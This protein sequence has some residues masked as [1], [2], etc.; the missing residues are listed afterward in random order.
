[1][2]FYYFI[3]FIFLCAFVNNKNAVLL[4]FFALF[5]RNYHCLL[6]RI[7]LLFLA[8]IRKQNIVSAEQ[9]WLIRKFNSELWA[10]PFA[11]SKPAP[12]PILLLRALCLHVLLLAPFT[13]NL[14]LAVQEK[15]WEI[16]PNICSRTVFI[17]I[18]AQTRKTM[19]FTDVIVYKLHQK[20]A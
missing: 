1:M 4:S 7:M 5:L 19:T 20:G 18:P 2:R 11:S 8:K 9:Q 14:T 3:Y 17:R 12:F 15:W 13:P 10:G 6:I 16:Y